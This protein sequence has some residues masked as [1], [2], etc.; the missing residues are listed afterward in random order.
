MLW[1]GLL[2]AVLVLGWTPLLLMAAALPFDSP[3]F[4]ARYTEIEQAIAQADVI[5]IGRV[6][7][8]GPLP[9][10]DSGRGMASQTVVY[11]LL[12]VLKGRVSD[13][14]VTIRHLVGTQGA[15]ISRVP[16]GSE[17]IVLARRLDDDLW[18]AGS[19]AGVIAASEQNI[20]AVR[21]LIA[22]SGP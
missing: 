8:L 19:E 18:A 1:K 14:E 11:E 15:Y 2:K 20:A 9:K 4:N 13:A 22:R 16:V 21:D 12:D 17:H 6:V 5:F 3:A 10:Y 7:S